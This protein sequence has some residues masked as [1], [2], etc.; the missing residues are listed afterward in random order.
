MALLITD[1]VCFRRDENGDVKFPLELASGLEAAAIG[2]RVRIGLAAG[3]VFSDREVGIPY[4][5][6]PDAGVE[7]RAAILGQAF[8]EPKARAAFRREILTTPGVTDIPTLLFAFDPS[9]RTL[10]VTFVARTRWGDTP[11]ETVELEV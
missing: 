2:V 6:N 3:E 7:A 8:D 11:R 9:A 5:P 4:V 10:S 1:P